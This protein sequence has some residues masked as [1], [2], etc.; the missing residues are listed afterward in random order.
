MQGMSCG[1]RARQHASTHVTQIPT[2]YK[3]ISDDTF[4][5]HGLQESD[6]YFEYI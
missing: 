4:N 6:K 2:Q 3:K 5:S 1:V